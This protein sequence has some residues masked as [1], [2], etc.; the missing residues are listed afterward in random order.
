MKLDY[1]P[2]DNIIG[3]IRHGLQETVSKG[4]RNLVSYLLFEI[5]NG[6]GGNDWI[7]QGLVH[8]K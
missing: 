1:L 3:L 6:E 2:S 8:T 7:V 5:N 4:G